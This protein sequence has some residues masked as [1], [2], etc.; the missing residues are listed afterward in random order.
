VSGN[1]VSVF[2]ALTCL[3]GL[4]L[5]TLTDVRRARPSLRSGEFWILSGD[6]HV[7]AFPGDGS[8]TPLDL[9]DE[10]I[11]AGL[12]VI[13]ITN[14][15]LIATGR[16]A[17]WAANGNSGPI[18]IGGEEITNP[19]YH[20]IAVGVTHLVGADRSATEAVAAVHAQGAVAIAA[21]P[22]RAFRGYDDAALAAV[23]GT[24]VAHPAKPAEAREFRETFERA[25]RLNPHIAPIGSSDIHVTPS[26]GECRTFLFVKERTA[27]GVLEA[28]R[29]GRTVAADEAGMLYGSPDLVAHVR[30]AAIMGRSTA[31][32]GWRRVSV[33]LTWLGLAGML[34]F[35]NGSNG[36][37][38]E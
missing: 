1:R 9:R 33:G 30:T 15:N 32:A 23:D 12:D 5:G 3:A 6:F 2:F 4:I 35:G 27:A 21:H 11:R 8:L 19:N 29:A 36:S 16:F 7:H 13:A 24:E 14:H 18:V 38:P 17:E 22:T 37:R 34:I 26:L 28:I 31:H 20:M 25:R 10:A